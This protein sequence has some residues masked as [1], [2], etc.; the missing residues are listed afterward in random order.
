[1]KSDFK[2]IFFSS[3]LTVLFIVSNLIG[4]KYTSFGEMLVSVNFITYPFIMLCLLILM[5]KYGKK[6]TYY[7]I[8]STI[9][10]QIFALLTYSFVVNSNSQ[11]VLPDLSNSINNVFGV[12]EVSMLVSMIAF[13]IS[14]YIFIYL[15]D[16]FKRNAKRIIGVILGTFFS[17]IVYGLIY[18]VVCYYVINQDFSSIF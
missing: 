10:I 4:F 11:Q 3:L 13:I 14:N 18:N 1:M 7:T 6:E 2:K 9:F 17:L 8:I 15:F 12:N 5:D 16:F